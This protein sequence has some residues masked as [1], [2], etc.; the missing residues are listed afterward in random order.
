L[1]SILLSGT[2]VAY[3]ARCSAAALTLPSFLFFFGIGTR[4]PVIYTLS[5]HD[6]LPICRRRCSGARRLRASLMTGAPVSSRPCTDRSDRRD[7]K[8]TRLN[9]SHVK[10]SY[11]VFCLKKKKQ[12]PQP[13][14]L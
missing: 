2:C 4:T 7:R 12:T 9:S 6:A 1:I 10:I 14:P 3:A 13:L 5:L 11:A 8:S